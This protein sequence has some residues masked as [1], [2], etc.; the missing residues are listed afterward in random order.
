MGWVV[1]YGISNLYEMNA[2]M[3]PKKGVLKLINT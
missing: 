3:Q 1:L 2:Q